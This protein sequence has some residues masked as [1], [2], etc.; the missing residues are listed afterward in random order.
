MY[1]M[2]HA[3]IFLIEKFLFIIDF[4]HIFYSFFVLSAISI[5]FS[6][7]LSYKRLL[8]IDPRYSVIALFPLLGFVTDFKWLILFKLNGSTFYNFSVAPYLAIL[9]M[10]FIILLAVIPGSKKSNALY[11]PQLQ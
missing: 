9:G 2:F 5:A 8:D 7:F 3:V 6:C 11:P 4:K 1:L 10:V